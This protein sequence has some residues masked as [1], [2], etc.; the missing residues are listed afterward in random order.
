MLRLRDCIQDLD[1]LKIVYDTQGCRAVFTVHLNTEKARKDVIRIQM[2]SLE[3]VQSLLDGATRAAGRFLSRITRSREALILSL[4]Y[5][6][7]V[8][9]NGRMKDNIFEAGSLLQG[10]ISRRWGFSRDTTVANLSRAQYLIAA[11]HTSASDKVVD[12]SE[13]TTKSYPDTLSFP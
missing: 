7:V 8:H 13:R 10:D 11:W 2:S 4:A 1:E 6:V 3:T 5:D 12:T 9:N